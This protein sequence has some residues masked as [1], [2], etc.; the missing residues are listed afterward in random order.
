MSD[1]TKADKTLDKISEIVTKLEKDLAKE[2][3]ES[4]EGHK[5]RAWFEEHKAI[6]EIKRTLH[7]VGKF[8]KYDEDAYNKFMK[9]YENVIDDFDKN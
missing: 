5:V 3:T 1:T 7:G 8:D 2:S 9:D 6:H 4:A